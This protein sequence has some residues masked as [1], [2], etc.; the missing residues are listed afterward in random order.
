M[1]DWTQYWGVICRMALKLCHTG[2]VKRVDLENGGDVD[3]I[4]FSSFHL[5]D[6]YIVS[7]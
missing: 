4:I 5:A 3:M 2:G 7:Y 1:V 6:A